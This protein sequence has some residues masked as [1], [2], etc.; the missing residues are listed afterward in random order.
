MA[1][2]IDFAGHYSSAS[3][4]CGLACTSYFF[5]DRNSGD[6]IA[7]DDDAETSDRMIW[8]IRT[9]RDSDILTVT[10]GDRDGVGGSCTERTF[11]W[12][13]RTFQRLSDFRPVS[14]PH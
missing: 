10:Y 11:R 7:Y 4:S 8:N 9:R 3:V 12:T 13:G 1:A 2:E 6:V 14:C 5:V